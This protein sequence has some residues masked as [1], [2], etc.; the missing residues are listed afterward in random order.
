[1]LL[2]FFLVFKGNKQLICSLKCYLDLKMMQIL[3]LGCLYF[4]I[5]IYLFW[6]RISDFWKVDALIE[7]NILKIAFRIGNSWNISSWYLAD[8]HLSLN[9]HY[10]E[11]VTLI[12]ILKYLRWVWEIGLYSQSICIMRQYLPIKF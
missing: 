11:L 9:K 12:L 8:K 7:W 10:F 1:M 3:I 4:S 6:R 2:S 5:N